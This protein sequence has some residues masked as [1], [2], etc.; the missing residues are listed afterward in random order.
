MSYTIKRNVKRFWDILG[1]S[2][3]R[4]ETR[5]P[6][7]NYWNA[8]G[9]ATDQLYGGLTNIQKSRSLQYM[10]GLQTELD[11]FYLVIYSGIESNTIYAQDAD[12]FQYI[13]DDDNILSIP[14][15]V[16][17]YKDTNDVQL[18]GVYTEG[19]DYTISGLNTLVWKRT[20][21]YPTPDPRYANGNLMFVHAPIT[22]KLDPVLL[23]VWAPIIN[24]DSLT[25]LSETYA[26]AISGIAS[27]A[28]QYEHMKQF[29]WALAYKKSQPP[30]VKTLSDALGI[31]HGVPFAYTSGVLS[32]APAGNHY[33]AYVNN[34][35]YVLPSG[36]V[37]NAPGPIDKFSLLASGVHVYDWVNGYDILASRVNST[38]LR[39]TLYINY[40]SSLNIC[41]YDQ[42]YYNTYASGLIPVHFFLEQ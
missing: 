11:N 18:S 20:S 24:L 4:F 35:A 5:Q 38:Q 14:R 37:P 39:K 17:Y 42:T 19:V 25:L 28:Q 29:V 6:I 30:T 27:L 10:S 12:L 36:L 16:R 13:L 23:K 2:W 1:T 33:I 9:Y 3:Y 26:P 32:Y 21:G 7:E 34:M 15:L 31:A 41:N 40:D 8:T 22:Y